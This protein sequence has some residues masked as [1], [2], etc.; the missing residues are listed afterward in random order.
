MKY[1]FPEMIS[2]FFQRYLQE[3]RGLSNDTVSTYAYSIQSFIKY[4]AKIGMKEKNITFND[5]TKE[6]VINYLNYLE[7]DLSQSVKTRNLRL[8]ALHSFCEYV[9]EEDISQY[10]RCIEILNVPLKKCSQSNIEFIE[11]EDMKQLF[12]KPNRY[13]KKGLRDLMIMALLYDSACR[14]NEFINICLRDID[15]DKRILSVTG[16]GRKSRQIPISKQVIK[17]LS[18]YLNYYKKEKSDYLFTNSKNEKLTRPG[19]TYII[20]KYVDICKKDNKDYHAGNITPHIFRHSKATHLLESGINI[21]YIRDF[22]GHESVITTELYAK[23]NPE[24]LKRALDN[25]TKQLNLQDEH[26]NKYSDNEVT[27]ILDK[28]KK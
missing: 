12:T 21:Y 18:E 8:S 27:I 9:M 22:L 20:H 3:Q 26:F 19:I 11:Y 16:K 1:K 10:N 23:N 24:N 7:I 17:L 4:L 6:T 25:H 2:S 5:L 14:I 13:T 15:M 28:F